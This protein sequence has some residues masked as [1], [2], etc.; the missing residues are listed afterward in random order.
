MPKSGEELVPSHSLEGLVGKSLRVYLALFFPLTLSYILPLLPFVL[1]RALVPMESV[2]ARWSFSGVLAAVESFLSLAIL[3]HLR[4][5]IDRESPVR[6]FPYG[7]FSPELYLRLLATNGLVYLIITLPMLIAD[8]TLVGRSGM[9]D[10]PSLVLVLGGG[11]AIIASAIFVLSSAIV[12]YEGKWGV[13][14]LCRAYRVSQGH[15]FTILLSL[16]GAI[17]VVGIPIGIITGIVQIMAGEGAELVDGLF[18][19]LITPLMLVWTF[20]AYSGIGAQH[21]TE[22][23]E[24]PLESAAT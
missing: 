5:F 13:G 7:G 21:M 11:W 8:P 12:A 17:C 19:F 6:F 15:Y 23:R 4:D 9:P 20:L 16:V 2:I 24:S 22:D 10:E 18:D 14:A 1:I 3:L